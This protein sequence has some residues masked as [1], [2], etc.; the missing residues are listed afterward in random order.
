MKPLK[1]HCERI[2]RNC[3]LRGSYAH[4]CGRNTQHEDEK[5]D[6]QQRN[7]TLHEL[8]FLGTAQWSWEKIWNAVV[9]DADLILNST[10]QYTLG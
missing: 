5:M 6:T 9:A 4:F 3:A 7:V 2:D 10:M 8:H 1:I